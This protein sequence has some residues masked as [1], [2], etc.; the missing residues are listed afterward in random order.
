[1]IIL[2]V[3][4]QLLTKT[5]QIISHPQIS[6]PF[7]FVGVRWGKAVYHALLRIVHRLSQNSLV[8]Y[9]GV[10]VHFAEFVDFFILFVQHELH[11]LLSFNHFQQNC[12]L[13]LQ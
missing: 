7:N 11:L 2:L 5:W 1:M 6:T 9:F 4:I 13:L 8:F 3:L 12:L 10:P